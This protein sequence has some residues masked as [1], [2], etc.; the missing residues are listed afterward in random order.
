M[1]LAHP[2]KL[3]HDVALLDEPLH[4]LTFLNALPR[5][6]QPASAVQAG[7]PL[8]RIVGWG[9]LEYRGMVWNVNALWGTHTALA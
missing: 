6:G 3:L 8:V 4:Q 1:H 2:P 9:V 5:L 7:P